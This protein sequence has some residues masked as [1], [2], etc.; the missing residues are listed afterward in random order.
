MDWQGWFTLAVVGGVLVGMLRG[1]AGPDLVMMAGLLTLAAVGILS[2]VETF[3]GFANP[4]LA[5]VGAVFILS[6]ALRETGA[7]E[8]TLGRIFVRAENERSGL[9]R[10]FPPL[11][12]LSAFLNNTTVVAMTTPV[13]M[14]W[15]RRH[16]FS[17]SRFLIPLSYSSI[18]GGVTTLMGTSTTLLVAGLILDADMPPMAFFEIGAVGLPICLVGLLYLIFVAPRLLPRRDDGE[19]LGE[20]RREY[21]SAMRVE[22][23]CPLVGQTVEEAGLRHL[24]GLFLIEIDRDGRMISPVAPDDTIQAN[25]QLV[26]AGV[27]ATIV[28]LQRIRGLVPA[29][30][31]EGAPISDPERNLAEAVVS[32]SSPLVNRSIRDANFRTVYDAAVVAVHRNAARVGGKIG[33]I[34]IRPGDTLLLQVGPG[35]ARAHS[36]SSDF[37]L[38]SELSDSEPP[39]FDR[40]WVA[41]GVMVAM[42]AV[43]T[44]N[45]LSIS[46]A[47][48]LA[49]GALL[50]TRC[51][52]GPGARRSVQWPVLIVI[53]AGLGIALA[54]QKT[55]AAGFI[56]HLL[57]GNA[58]P[59]GPLATL[60]VIYIVTLAL[61]ESLNHTA[62]AAIMFPIA[63]ASAGE[64]VVEPRGF[65]MAV[66]V[67]A[68]C[69]FA[70]PVS[71]QTHLIVMG[72]GRYR[73]MDFVRVGLPLD[74]LCGIV[75]LL[76]IPIIWGF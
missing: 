13:V 68:S 1:F 6:A 10:M 49:A 70:S 59:Y 53:G 5:T 12:F 20:R 73:F 52:N 23:D 30:V 72:P 50:V 3:S 29:A 44:L 51:I 55:G 75:A 15:A 67:A 43:V 31:E 22:S 33:D 40:A 66:T 7:L 41:I 57:V 17:P 21:T 63:V 24:P 25:D 74:I 58:G 36:N 9:I 69:S 45:I 46:V 2:P 54:M 35:F 32:D 34:V 8:A 64:L 62:A 76:L 16:R 11:A 18:L 42:V 27:V 14:D 56:A 65:I 39:R 37:Y 26:F 71:Y 4:A 61:T 38:V 47:A 19:E 60:A 48:F 28:D